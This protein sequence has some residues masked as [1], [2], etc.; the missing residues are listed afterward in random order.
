M[1][2]QKRLTYEEMADA[3]AKVTAGNHL[4]NNR[5]TS[6]EEVSRTLRCS[7]SNISRHM[8]NEKLKEILK[9]KGIIANR[10]AKVFYFTFDPEEDETEGDLSVEII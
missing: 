5:A 9:Q 1:P 6:L 7:K 4:L 10:V 8:S 3:I 2:S